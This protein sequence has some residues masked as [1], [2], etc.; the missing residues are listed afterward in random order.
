MARQVKTVEE[1][2][3]RIAKVIAKTWQ[4]MGD[5]SEISDDTGLNMIR[6][7]MDEFDPALMKRAIEQVKGRPAR[8]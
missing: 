2:L 1:L 8:R 3:E 4:G 5:E 7:L 6:D